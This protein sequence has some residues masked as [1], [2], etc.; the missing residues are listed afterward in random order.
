MP[1]TPPHRHALLI[2]L[3]GSYTPADRHALAFELPPEDDGGPDPEPVS[4]L[5]FAQAGL[6]WRRGLARDP[7]WRLRFGPA[8]SRDLG[9]ALAWAGGGA[10]DRQAGVRWRE[11]IAADR[12]VLVASGTAEPV[13][14]E[15]HL[16]WHNPVAVDRQA[17]AGWA[18]A[19][20]TESPPRE[21]RW[22]HPPPCDRMAGL[23]WRRA[24]RLDLETVFA[25]GSGHAADLQRR[26]PW[27]MGNAPAFRYLLPLPPR[28]PRPP[29]PDCYRPERHLLEFRLGIP[30]AP[31]VPPDRHALD[32]RLV[33]GDGRY[34]NVRRTL[35]MSHSLSVV[36]L[37]DRLPLAV[38][39]VSLGAD[40]DS[41]SWSLQMGFADVASLLAVEPTEETKHSVEITLD[42]YVFTA[43]VEG[44]SEDRRF[45]S[46]GG[47]ISG[48]SRSAMLAAPDA[49]QRAYSNPEPATAQQ[50]ALREL[51]FTGFALDWQIG[52]WT[53]PAG[54][55][56]YERESPIT[57]IARIA[58]ASG[59][60]LQTAPGSDTLVVTPRMP[61]APWNFAG[62]TPDFT[63]AGGSWLQKGKRWNGGGRY[64][65][66]WVG[67]QT[68]GILANVYRDGTPGSPYAQLLT[69]PLIT[70]TVPAMPRG[71]QVIADSLPRHEIPI[72]LP[73][74]PAPLAPGLLM[75]G[76]L[77]AIEDT[78]WGHYRAI[79]D[80]VQISAEVSEQGLVTARQ[81]AN[82]WRYLP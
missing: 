65:G 35:S 11:A 68:Q 29:P 6:P 56:S 38:R 53:V 62:E 55:W 52:D 50:L 10:A 42:G 64:N 25:W 27:G 30:G 73:L 3:G 44:F 17:R 70:S 19:E 69:D 13:D 15:A 54:A 61:A 58:T 18:A 5:A 12:R 76:E 79:V 41:W 32:L 16:R 14:R 9:A 57:A 67:G 82:L 40:R 21:L 26:A 72:E 4:R 59:A 66:V 20:R 1:Y 45:G 31:Y 23:R 7:Q 47:N 78:V 80:S 81:Q 63:L 60:M 48:Q 34:F 8:A 22:S 37:P 71:L 77:G 46:R 49:P 2:E 39:S 36:R 51:E 24:A 74:T 43:Q 75:P 33:C 28:P